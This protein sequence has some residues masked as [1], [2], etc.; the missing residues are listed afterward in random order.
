MKIALTFLALNRQL[1]VRRIAL[2]QRL[3]SE[4]REWTWL[5]T[6][7]AIRGS[8]TAWID[9]LRAR[10]PEAAAESDVSHI[11]YTG[12]SAPNAKPRNLTLFQK[13]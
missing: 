13:R 12:S 4:R 7:C 1:F 5:R 6:E 3:Y 11:S 10:A 8:A 2:S 9:E